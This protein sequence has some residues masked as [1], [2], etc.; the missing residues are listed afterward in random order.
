MCVES[1]DE[2]GRYLGGGGGWSFII[3]KLINHMLIFSGE[4]S[5]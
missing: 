3:D 2:V 4:I 1:R 5:F